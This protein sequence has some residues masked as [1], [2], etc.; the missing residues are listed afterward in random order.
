MHLTIFDRIGFRDVL[1]VADD[2]GRDN[3][4]DRNRR[5]RSL[6]GA[7]ARGLDRI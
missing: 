5:D 4:V 2:A 7:G 1:Y 3:R 6:F